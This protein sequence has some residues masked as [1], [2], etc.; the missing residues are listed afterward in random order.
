MFEAVKIKRKSI[1]SGKRTADVIKAKKIVC[2]LYHKKG[3]TNDKIAL[4]LNMSKSGIRYL[5]KSLNN[6]MQ[7][8]KQLKKEI[9]NYENTIRTNS[10]TPKR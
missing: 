4:M 1:R 2:Y 6:E 3:L 8:N 10:K 5:L 9:E 7:V